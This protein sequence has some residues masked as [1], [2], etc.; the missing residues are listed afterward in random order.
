MRVGLPQEYY[1]GNTFR[2]ELSLPYLIFIE[3]LAII[4]HHIHIT[5][6]I[7]CLTTN[8]WANALALFFK[9]PIL[10]QKSGIALIIFDMTNALWSLIRAVFRCV[11][12][13]YLTLSVTTASVLLVL[14][15]P[16]IFVDEPKFLRFACSVQGSF[17]CGVVFALNIAFGIDVRLTGV[18]PPPEAALVISNHQTQDWVTIYSLAIRMGTLGFVRPV[19]KRITKY[20]LGWGVG[21]SLCYWPFVSRNYERD[22]KELR[23]TFAVYKASKLPVQ[24]WL[25]PEGTRRTPKKIEQSQ[26]VA[27]E[28]N[29]PVWSRVMLPRHRGFI[30]AL[31]SLQGV[32][33]VIHDITL[34]YEGWPE[35]IPRFPM[36]LF[37]DYSRRPHKVH[38]H[39]DR[40]DVNS[41]PTEDAQR[42]A[43][44][45][46]RFAAKEERLTY[47]ETH[48]S[49]PGPSIATSFN[50][51]EVVA[52]TLAWAFG[53]FALGFLANYAIRSFM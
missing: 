36:L 1:K 51:G 31:Q 53:T 2:A 26:A 11:F 24:V 33:N 50:R 4:P 9:I 30:L 44:L 23:K 20:A 27:K 29:Y 34:A 13:V 40:I 22:V 3:T 21:M 37:D 43:W 52:H 49:F 38:I 5:F 15:S 14:F 28:R 6:V 48:G 18:L 17:L 42:Q 45:M 47:F 39:I 12:L 41:I 16:L 35:V 10:L 8:S 32:I 19:I 25:F 46:R 7:L